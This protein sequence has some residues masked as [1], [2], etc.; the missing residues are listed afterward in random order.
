MQDRD[1]DLRESGGDT[2][3]ALIHA[4]IEAFGRDGYEAATTKAIAGAANANQALISYYFGSKEGLYVAAVEH[5]ADQIGARMGP[6]GECVES[7]TRRLEAELS[8]PVEDRR[9]RYFDLLC[10]MVD[11]FAEMLTDQESAAWAQVLVREQQQPG[12]AFDALY[13]RVQERVLSQMARLVARLN[14]ESSPSAADRLTVLTI[15]GQ[16]LVFRTARAAVVRFMG[17]ET[18]RTQQVTRIKHAV[19]RNLAAMLGVE[20]E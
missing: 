13:G 15:V 2:R 12:R 1:E 17:W 5:I 7:E 4:A 19:H 10:Q 9:T 6:I 3:S 16:V 20:Y 14:G 18:I 8:M 11:G